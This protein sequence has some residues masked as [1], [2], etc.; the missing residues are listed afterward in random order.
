ML[1]DYLCVYLNCMLLCA[2]YGSESSSLFPGVNWGGM[3]VDTAIFLQSSL[4]IASV[5]KD[6]AGQ[7]RIFSKLGALFF[8]FNFLFIFPS[9]FSQFVYRCWLLVVPPG[10]RDYQQRVWLS[11]SV[12][13]LF[14]FINATFKWSN[15]LDKLRLISAW[16]PMDPPY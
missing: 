7:W 1:H 14:H 12:S 9:D 5:E 4:D 8:C 2:R 6:A 16:I 13:I 11:A 10:G 3:T 15:L